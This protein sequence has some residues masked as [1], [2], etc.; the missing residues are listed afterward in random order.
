MGFF[1]S[2]RA[3]HFDSNLQD[4]S[5]VLRALRSRFY[6]KGKGKE[7]DIDG[8]S[9]SN[10]HSPT[11]FA[12]PHAPYVEK[13]SF[14]T[15][16]PRVSKD[17]HW[18]GTS[19][20][21]SRPQHD[22]RVDEAT[23]PRSSADVLTITLAQRL[24]ELATANAEGLL[25]DEE[26]RLLR[27]NLFERLTT[28]SSVPTE[29]PLVPM[30]NT[31]RVNAD[32][33]TSISSSHDRR[34]SSQYH[35]Q[36]SRTSSLQSKKSISS[37]VTSLL[38]RATSR[39]IVSLPNDPQASDTMSVFSKAS[40]TE[41]NGTT[42]RTI[43]SQT[44]DSSLRDHS[45]LRS[46]RTV[47]GASTDERL[48]TLSTR[49]TSLRRGRKRSGSSAPP[50]AFPGSPRSV[51]TSAHL[52]LLDGLPNDDDLETSKDIRTQLELVEAEGRRLLDAFNGLELSTLTGRTRRPHMRPPIPLSTSQNILSPTASE[53][54]SMR[55]ARDPD[56][57]SFVSGGSI[58]TT[59]SMKRSPS[60]RRIPPVPSSATLGSQ[61]KS[62]SRK[63][64]MSSMSSRGRPGIGT[65]PGLSSQL[66]LA[67]SSS[68]NLTKSSAHLPLATVAE[69]ESPPMG[70]RLSVTEDSRWTG[71]GSDTLSPTA[72]MHSSRIMNEDD[73]I[74]AIE[75]EL[76]D[77]RTR[78]AEVTARYEAR[79]EYLRARLKGAEL[80]EKVM[81]K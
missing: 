52:A 26:Y 47:A 16:R 6:G 59:H 22:D 8:D 66:G 67:S 18:A 13:Q 14:S 64:S 7:R 78:R 19:T 10:S 61:H 77:I 31:M 39:R 49:S 24:N 40:T 27:Q 2:R 28:G 72:S 74:R 65:L 37:T 71:A 51:D 43:S 42:P 62:V 56:A 53:R 20:S 70:H 12:S 69:A 63:G 32:L 58:R 75:A 68:V 57:M 76:V 45:R 35:L 30:N 80:R 73:D 1:S 36:S 44:S 21:A 11:S 41:R 60:D 46:R 5:N 55:G 79:L 29:T 3:E 17:S 34:S 33:R 25:S 48:M 50:S 23:N 54:R 15:S 9:L 38:R 81:R 4:E